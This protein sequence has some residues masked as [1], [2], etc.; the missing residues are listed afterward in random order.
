[1]GKNLAKL[2]YDY[3]NLYVECRA[4]YPLKAKSDNTTHLCRNMVAAVRAE[5]DSG[6]N[7]PN[8]V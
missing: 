3:K 5:V 1:M 2:C 7:Q 4:R 6:E 8:A